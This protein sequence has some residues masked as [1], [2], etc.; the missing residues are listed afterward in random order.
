MHS[1]NELTQEIFPHVEEESVPVGAPN[2]WDKVSGAPIPNKD[3]EEQDLPLPG[4]A[5]RG[6][7]YQLDSEA[8]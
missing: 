7:F 2:L 5:R 8:F 6:R 4:E 3:H 1:G